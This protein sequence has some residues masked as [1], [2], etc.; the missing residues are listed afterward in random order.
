MFRITQSTSSSVARSGSVAPSIAP[1]PSVDPSDRLWQDHGRDRDVVATEPPGAELLEVAFRAW[2]MGHAKA[3]VLVVGSRDPV[4]VPLERALR[5]LSTSTEPLTPADGT[6]LGLT[7]DVTIGMAASELLRACA[8][9]NGPRCRSYRSATYFLVGRALLG[10][11][12]EPQES[13]A[14][15]SDITP[16]TFAA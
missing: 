6:S 12:D 10:L 3:D 1:T 8:D 11:D 7:A 5:C 9:P 2:V 16:G 4:A 14:P 13:C 15:T